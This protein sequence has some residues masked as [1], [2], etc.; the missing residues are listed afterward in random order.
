MGQGDLYRQG[1]R[2]TAIE[3]SETGVRVTANGE[4]GFIGDMLVGADG[5]HSAVR[6]A[7]W[8]MGKQREPGCFEGD[9][10]DG[11]H[12]H[13]LDLHRPRRADLPPT[14]I[15]CN[16]TALF[17]VSKLSGEAPPSAN[18]TV[19]PGQAVA[20]IANRDRGYFLFYQLLPRELRGA[21]IPQF[22]AQQRDRFAEE[23]AGDVL[24][25]SFTFGNLYQRRVRS[26]LVPL[27]NYAF[28]RWHFGRII[29]LGDTVHKVG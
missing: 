14:A 18:N 21:E 2:V 22:T 17:G 9:Q 13:S 10:E 28:K 16:F 12:D 1:K 29:C 27:Q 4:E 7:M 3:E 20:L 24:Q 11:K 15:R 26:V 5:V 8:H 25:G 19:G 6:K 23:H